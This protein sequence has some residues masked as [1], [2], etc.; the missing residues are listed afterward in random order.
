MPSIFESKQDTTNVDGCK[1]LIVDIII[2]SLRDYIEYKD[3]A[4]SL[5]GKIVSVKHSAKIRDFYSAKFF[6]FDEEGMLIFYCNMLENINPDEIRRCALEFTRAET[7]RLDVII[8]SN[9]Q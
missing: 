5:K 8:K 4:A 2:S 3:L 1:K 9:G 6:L 7:S